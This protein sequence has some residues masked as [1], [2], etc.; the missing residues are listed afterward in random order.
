MIGI[1]LATLLLAL[2]YALGGH[3]IGVV[4][5]VALGCLWL[6]GLWR[7]WNETDSLGIVG[8]TSLAAVGVW[9]ALAIPVLLA[10]LVAALAAW[11]L[12]RFAQ[13]LQRAGH[14]SPTAALARAHLR[15]LLAV[16][17]IGLLLS[18]VS[19]GI[20]LPIGFGWALL[21]G[22]LAILGVSRTIRWLSQAGN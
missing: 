13:R 22:A 6:A 17:G 3:W 21:L 12:D 18:A 16:A 8:F 10:S 9:L 1:G 15:R 7:G 5:S 4:A 11:D 20:Q 14:A 19:F 2:D